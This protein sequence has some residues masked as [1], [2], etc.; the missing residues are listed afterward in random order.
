LSATVLFRQVLKSLDYFFLVAHTFMMKTAL[1]NILSMQK[2]TQGC[3]AAAPNKA[4]YKGQN[5]GINK[6]SNAWATV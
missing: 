4:G 1:V 3:G 5:K 6:C 2:S